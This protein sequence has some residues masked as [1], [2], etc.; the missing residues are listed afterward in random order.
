MSYIRFYPINPVPKPRQ[1]R[2]DKWKKR[3]AVMKYRQFKDRVRLYEVMLPESSAKITFFVPMPKSWSNK[4]KEKMANTPHQS[5]P[6]IDNYLKALFDAVFDDDSKI[7]HIG[8]VAKIW[9]YRGGIEIYYPTKGR[10]AK[11]VSCAGKV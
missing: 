9:S 8:G 1:T 7:W 10:R 11:D 4:K 5:K 6:D 2:S 3:P